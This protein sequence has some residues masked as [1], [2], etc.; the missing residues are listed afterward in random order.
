MVR[1][2]TGPA[3]DL[4][5]QEYDT[6]VAVLGERALVELS[7]LVGYYVTLALQMRI[8]RVAGPGG[9][10]GLG[11]SSERRE[12]AGPGALLGCRGGVGFVRAAD[13][14]VQRPGVGP[15]ADGRPRLPLPPRHCTCLCSAT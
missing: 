14:A 15:A 3:A 9:G 10:G 5:D 2:L 7:T 13:S 1:A 4:D 11:D 6:A 8:F 12:G